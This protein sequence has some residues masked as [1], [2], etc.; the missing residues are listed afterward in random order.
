ME[1]IEAA[2]ELQENETEIPTASG[3][4]YE[5]RSFSIVN[6]A[7]DNNLV[8]NSNETTIG[9][10]YDAFMQSINAPQGLV[11]R[12]KSWRNEVGLYSTRDKTSH[13]VLKNVRKEKSTFNS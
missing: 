11:N 4:I 3:N 13:Y 1:D 6:I 7:E 2:E 12:S 8:S 9:I 5:N 10:E